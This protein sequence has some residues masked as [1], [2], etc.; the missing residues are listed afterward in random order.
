MEGS[1]KA[2]T[3]SYDIGLRDGE[4][5]ELTFFEDASSRSSE[6]EV[7]AM[8]TLYEYCAS[9]ARVKF[10]RGKGV[11]S[12]QVIFPGV[13]SRPTLQMNSDGCLKLLF[14]NLR[15][16][17]TSYICRDALAKRLRQTSLADSIPQALRSQTVSID[18]GKWAVES[19]NLIQALEYMRSKGPQ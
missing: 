16:D 4:N 15:D 8:R 7:S 10:G 5:E 2:Q 18:S 3:C 14:G 13:S 17:E 1:V 6:S 19:Q 12:F 9:V 11:K